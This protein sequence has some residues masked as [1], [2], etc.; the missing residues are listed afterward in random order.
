MNELINE[1]KICLSN[2][3]YIT[4]LNTALIIPDI[5]SAL[6][7]S[8]GRTDGKKYS[9]WFNDYVSEKYNGN[10][11]GSDVYKIRCATLHQGKFNSNYDFFDIIL[12]QPPSKTI[13]MHNCISAYNGGKSDVALILNI[14]I[15][16]NDIINGLNDWTEDMKQNH[17]YENNLKQSFK[18]LPNGLLPHISGI[19]IFA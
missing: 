9:N 11:L 5:C 6:Q 4:A 17:F 12:F 10:L 18:L 2:K 15:F 14:E 1:L 13:V 3:L 7:S 16:I 19:P 8:N